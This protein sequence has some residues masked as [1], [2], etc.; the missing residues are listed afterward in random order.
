MSILGNINNILNEEE[1]NQN[2]GYTTPAVIRDDK[3]YISFKK[4][5][6]LS[7]VLH[8]T[9]VAIFVIIAFVLMLLGINILQHKP[10]KAKMND[11]EFV[12][13]EK[14][15]TPINK[16]TR[17][18]S[19]KNS[20]AGG[21]HDP[22]RKVSMPSPTPAKT[23]KASK[24]AAAPKAPAKAQPKPAAPKKTVKP[25]KQQQQP[26]KTTTTPKQTSPVPSK[27]MVAPKPAAP[28]YKPSVNK[29]ASPRPTTTPK[30][31]FNVPMPPRASKGSLATGPVS[32]S[33]TSKAPVGGGYS[34]SPSLAPTYKGSGSGSSGGSSAGSRGTS[35]SRGGTGNYGNPGPGNPN[36]RPGIDAIAE[37]DF[38]PYMRDLQRRIKMNWD[39]PKGNESK[40]VVL[41]FKIAR[42]GRLLSCTVSKSSGLASA[43][44]AALQAVRL[45][46]PFRPLPANFRGSSVDI[47]FT[48]DYN[49]FG[50]SY[51]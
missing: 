6:L 45:T 13:V 11:I 20:R 10:P 5:L 38:G 23:Q 12:L 33:G 32:G 42:D 9:G 49:V 34:P 27:K 29:P 48:F 16:N 39:P 35:P 30:S 24:P 3:D 21:K 15:A 37:P 1:D 26:K 17:F 19:D 25:A 44:N 14:E 43:D 22:N 31:S 40:R 8:P 2:T 7:T 18:R 46:A 41:L 47:Q 4:A 36:G 28:S 50:G 51:R